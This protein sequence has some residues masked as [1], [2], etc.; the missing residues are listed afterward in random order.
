MV[1]LQGPSNDAANAGAATKMAV[2][3]NGDDDEGACETTGHG[4]LVFGIGCL[5][6]RWRSVAIGAT[7]SSSWAG[8][9]GSLKRMV[10]RRGR[11][12]EEPL[13]ELRDEK[14]HA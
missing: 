1:T 8:L 10:S 12:K 3:E 5:S 11:A 6:D 9:S 7:L 2:G 14:R 4:N 13:A